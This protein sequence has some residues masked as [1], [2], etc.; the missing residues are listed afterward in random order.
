[1]MGRLDN[2]IALVTGAGAGLGESCARRF[3][4]EGAQLLLTDIDTAAVQA[5]AAGSPAEKAG[6]RPGDVVLLTTHAAFRP[7]MFEY[8][9]E[10]GI[11]VFAEKSF[12]T[13]A[14]NVRRWLA[15]A[16][17]ELALWDGRAAEALARLAILADDPEAGGIA[18]PADAA[19]MMQ[20]GVDGVF[21]GSGIF[22][23]DNPARRAKAIVEATTHY[24]D[25]KI[26]AEISQN[27]GEPMVGISVSSLA[28]GETLADRGW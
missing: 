24:R 18:T 22:K 10:K 3:H 23:S 16:H 14:P 20:I 7:M 25:P 21:V 9:V 12:A 28:E 11:N 17:A 27:L 5:V 2:K 8:A 19:L 26:L 13:D 6:I 15:A 4:A 1:M